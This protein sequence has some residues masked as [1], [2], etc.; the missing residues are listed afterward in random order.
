MNSQDIHFR[1]EEIL[2]IW[3]Q[4]KICFRKS[5][6]KF[7]SVDVLFYREIVNSIP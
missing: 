1:E 6:L 7:E 5:F 3:N 2:Y 4:L